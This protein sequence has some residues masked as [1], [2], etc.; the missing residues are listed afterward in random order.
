MQKPQSHRER[1]AEGTIA[2]GSLHQKGSFLDISEVVSG[3][4]SLVPYFAQVKEQSKETRPS[5]ST[6]AH[7]LLQ[8][9]GWQV[10]SM[11]PVPGTD[12]AVN[13]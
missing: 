9:R 3:C 4:P 7:M 6:A 8:E 12:E 10:R 1:G 5:R 2:R 11:P 13:W